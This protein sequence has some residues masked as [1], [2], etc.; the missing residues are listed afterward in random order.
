MMKRSDIPGYPKLVQRFE[1]RR[2]PLSEGQKG[3]SRYFGFDYM[4]AAEFEWG[5]I[6]QSK[7]RVL[8]RMDQD[9]KNHEPWTVIPIT[10]SFPETLTGPKGKY[11][12]YYVGPKD[13]VEAART[14]F[15]AELTHKGLTDMK[16][17]AY[18]WESYEEDKYH[19]KTV[20]WWPVKEDGW[21]SHSEPEHAWAV[22]KTQGLAKNWI[23]ALQNP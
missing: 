17:P 1:E 8:A 20:G 18:L 9:R 5:A 15:T 2:N 22:F 21:S 14:W 16:E 10:V 6:P 7:K 4:G 23:L 3:I 12:C 13:Q 11:T 19:V